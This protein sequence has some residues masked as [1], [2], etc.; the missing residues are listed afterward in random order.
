MSIHA[1]VAAAY[2]EDLDPGAKLVLMAMCDSSDEHSGETAPGLPK[3]RAWS[4]RGKSQVLRIVKDLEGNPDADDNPTTTP[5][6]LV[7]VSRGRIGRRAVWRV[8]PDG[9]PKIPH[10]DEVAARYTDPKPDPSGSHPRDPLSPLLTNGD[11]PESYPQEGDKEGRA[12]ATQ[13]GE[14]VASTSS[15]GRTGATPSFN[16]SV[17]NARRGTEERPPVGDKPASRPSPSGFPGSRQAAQ[18]QQDPRTKR[19]HH[20]QPCP[21]ANHGTKGEVAGGCGRC[22]HAAVNSD[23]AALARAR[24]EARAATQAARRPT[25]TTTEETPQP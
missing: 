19:G 3:L 23:P 15:E 13:D 11:N 6:Y 5:R 7:Q 1:M 25:A 12:H 17:L 10:P 24:A 4:G 14:R 22:A 8:F 18:E 9:M 16:P 2:L 21:V 20:N